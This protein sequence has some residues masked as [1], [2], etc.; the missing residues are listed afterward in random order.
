MVATVNI[1]NSLK[2]YYEETKGLCLLQS[3]TVYL[4][5]EK[6]GHFVEENNS[7][8]SEHEV[9]DIFITPSVYGR[10]SNNISIV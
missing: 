4:N 1:I 10:R 6:C 3:G 9:E 8:Q 5:E 7:L 2:R